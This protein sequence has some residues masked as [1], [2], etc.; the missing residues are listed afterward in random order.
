MSEIVQM[1]IEHSAEFAIVDPALHGAAAGGLAL[2]H[3]T[4][5]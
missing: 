4:F 2:E 3:R 5:M 1:L